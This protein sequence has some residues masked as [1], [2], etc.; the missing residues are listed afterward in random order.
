MESLAEALRQVENHRS[1]QGKR[2]ELGALL[3]FH[4]HRDVVWLP[5]H[6]SFNPVGGNTRR[7]PCG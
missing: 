3:I 1:N 5:E 4:L 2:D 6:T 7:V